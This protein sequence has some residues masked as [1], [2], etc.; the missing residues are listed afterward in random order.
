MRALALALAAG[1]ALSAAAAS[2]RDIPR[3]AGPVM[4]EARVLSVSQRETLSSEIRSYLPHVQLQ[5]WIVRSLEGE[6]IEN[7]SIRAADTWKLGTKKEDR[8]A[9]LL[10]ALDD[11]RMRLEVGQGLEGEITDLQSSRILDGV[12][13]PAFRESRYFEGLQA[14]SRHV[15]VLA[16]GQKS[17]GFLAPEASLD[18]GPPVVL[19]LLFFA[20]VMFLRILAGGRGRRRSR[21][22]WGGLAGGGLWT[23]GRGGG[24][25]GGGGGWSG[26]GGG[27][28]GGG[29]SGSW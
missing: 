15:Y 25:W 28:S 13:R 14:A 12:L 18:S 5:I 3:L 1:V 29:S 20:F 19:V 27:F 23:G 4:D 10:V 8:G 16:G 11:R 26:G 17:Q 21:Y 22:Y 9:L 2:P 6:P 7:L 24:S